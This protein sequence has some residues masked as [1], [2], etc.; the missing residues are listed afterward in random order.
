M[1]SK[2]SSRGIHISANSGFMGL[3]DELHEAHEVIQ[4]RELAAFARSQY[5]MPKSQ[6]PQWKELAMKPYELPATQ[7][8][9]N[10]ELSSTARRPWQQDSDPS[11]LP[12]NDP[13]PT[14]VHLTLFWQQCGRGKRSQLPLI[15]HYRSPL[16]L[17]PLFPGESAPPALHPS[18]AF[19]NFRT[20]SCGE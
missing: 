3:L 18:A 12:Q 13:T 15:R 14:I 9:Q 7:Q 20:A 10:M 16:H 5:S 1:L 11:L 8:W 17:Q 2:Q 4:A 6:Q 19:Q